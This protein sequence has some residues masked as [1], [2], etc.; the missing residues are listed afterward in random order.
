MLFLTCE[1]IG[2]RPIGFHVSLQS[3]PDKTL[4]FLIIVIDMY[5]II[6]IPL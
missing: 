1:L 5:P 2:L 6:V 3:E 4:G